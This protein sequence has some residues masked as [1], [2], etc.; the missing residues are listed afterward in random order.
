MK[1]LVDTL[2]AK[3]GG[4]LTYAL[5]VFPLLGKLAPGHHFVVYVSNTIAPKFIDL[6]ANVEVRTAPWAEGS[7]LAHACWQQLS[8]PRMVR[9]E[10]FDCLYSA[11][12]F[13]P[14]RC[15]CRHVLL[16]R[17]P[18]Y[19]HHLYFSRMNDLRRRAGVALRR[20]LSVSCMRAADL[21]VF[22]THAMLEL[23]NRWG[24]LARHRLRA[25]HY[26][27]DPCY[28]QRPEAVAPP[29]TLCRMWSDSGLRLLAVGHLC[30]QKNYSTLFRAIRTVR[31]H[32]AAV[33]LYVAGSIETVKGF[34]RS[35]EKAEMD[36]CPPGSIILLGSLQAMQ[37][38]VAY[39]AASIFMFPS[40]LESFGHPMVE[41]MSFG[42][43]LIVAE[44]M[45]NREVCGDAAMYHR[46][47]DSDDL[48]TSLTKLAED[49][50]LRQHLRSSALSRANQFTWHRHA[51][52]LLR[53]LAGQGA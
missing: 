47:F 52:L 21:T 2:G 50:Q 3:I 13:G 25:I 48:A 10:R 4:A 7:A 20:A 42:L 23:A 6:P 15:P 36:S 41:A 40:Y 43:P 34:A 16:V 27:F 9:R 51:G 38:R 14:L 24:R 1:V 8:L 28:F 19:F 12:G 18:I 46:P 39:T 33:T 35:R 29:T 26:G 49:E 44:T 11:M 32:G 53:E 37:L 45:V 22:P 5:N 31:A 30:D 17:N